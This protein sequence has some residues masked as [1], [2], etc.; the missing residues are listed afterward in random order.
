MK[1]FPMIKFSFFV[2]LDIDECANGTHSCDVNA[3]CNNTQGSYNCKCKDGFRGD[4]MN[5]TGKLSETPFNSV[6]FVMLP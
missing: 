1:P 6:V 4:G 3:L 2:V 5:C